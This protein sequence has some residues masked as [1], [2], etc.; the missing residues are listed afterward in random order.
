[1]M[2]FIGVFWVLAPIIYCMFVSIIWESLGS[3]VIFVSHQYM[4][5]VLPTHLV[6]LDFR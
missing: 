3:Y 1:M 6:V 4:G 5:F 2:A